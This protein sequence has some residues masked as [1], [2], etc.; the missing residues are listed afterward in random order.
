MIRAGIVGIG[1]WGQTLVSSVQG[2]SEKIRFTAGVTGRKALAQEYCDKHGIRLLDSLD[3]MLADADIDAVVLATPHTQH[4]DQVVACAAAGKAVLVEKPFTLVPTDAKRAVAAI[5]A[6]GKPL[7]VAFNRRFSPPMVMLREM[8]QSGRLGT[9]LHVEGNISGSGGLRYKA[10]HWRASETESPAGGMTA[11]GVHMADAMIAIMGPVA[12]VRAVSE[13]RVLTTDVDDTTFAALKFKGGATGVLTTLFASQQFWRV[14]VFGDKG[15]AEV[16]DY[17]RLEFRPI[18][19][20]PEVIE[21][22]PFD[23]EE[24][25]LEAFADTVA[26]SAS[27]PVTLAD[28]EHGVDILDAVIRSAKSGET[29][30]L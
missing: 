10:G 12:S 18:E 26:G 5:Q 8:V 9:V 3:E 13:R 16:R 21:Y 22:P 30:T 4:A 20:K 27:Y 11:M 29:V 2:K 6:A 28:A 19:G 24:A 17:T 23:M 7:C 25:E 1:R 14:Q 15:W